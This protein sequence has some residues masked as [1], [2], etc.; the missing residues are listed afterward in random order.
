MCVLVEK[1]HL[2]IHQSYYQLPS[3]SHSVKECQKN[4]V[5]KFQ[6]KTCYTDTVS[7][8]F[9]VIS[10]IFLKEKRIVMR[11]WQV[12][13]KRDMTETSGYMWWTSTHTASL[14]AMGW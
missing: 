11:T 8:A 6:S 12:T 9:N 7:F 10:L 2:K 1:Q 5:Y 3:F 13:G 14:C 4:L